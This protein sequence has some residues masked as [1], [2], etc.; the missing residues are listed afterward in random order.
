MSRIADARRWSRS[1]GW[2]PVAR[3]GMGLVARKASGRGH[4]M[5]V[6]PSFD[7]MLASTVDGFRFSAAEMLVA[8]GWQP[9]EIDA[10]DD[11]FR[12]VARRLA[13]RYE[14]C[15]PLPFPVPFKVEEETS[16][17]LYSVARLL[18][19]AVV[20]ETGVANGHSS[21]LL[22]EALARNDHG[23]L[24]SF[25]IDDR[26]GKLV[27]DRARWRFRVSD[28]DSAA[29]DFSATVA[30]LGSVDFFFHDADHRYLSQL[31][32]YRTVWPRVRASGV[33]ASDDVDDSRAFFDFAAEIG[34]KPNL[35]LDR[36]KVVGAC[37]V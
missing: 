30:E 5:D 14:Q 13:E 36:T 20:V 10:L 1:L 6:R 19:P 29:Q 15:D 21:Y 23:T 11:E 34:R 9:A 35:L 18:R 27:E 22:L 26:A 28:L 33:F 2:A 31:A 17:F 7:D 12:E 16:R 25:D 32:E 24:Y 4:R 8:L 3:L 37:R